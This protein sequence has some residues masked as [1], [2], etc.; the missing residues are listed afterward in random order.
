VFALRHP[1]SG[2]GMQSIQALRDLINS[3]DSRIS[4]CRPRGAYPA[5]HGIRHL[6]QPRDD[7]G[8]AAATSQ[9][10]LFVQPD[11]RTKVNRSGAI[12][13]THA[14]HT[15]VPPIVAAAYIDEHC[16]AD[17]TVLDP[18]C[19][20]GMTGVGAGLVGRRAVLSDI[21][22]AAVHIARNYCQPCDSAAFSAAVER[23]LEAVGA[24]IDDLYCTEL[25]GADATVEH[26]VWSDVRACPTCA[27]TTLLRDHRSEGLRTLTCATCGRDAATTHADRRTAR[28]PPS[29][30]SA[31][32]VRARPRR[33]TQR[34][35]SDRRTGPRPSPRHHAP[36]RAFISIALPT[37]TARR[38]CR[39]TVR[40]REA[41]AVPRSERSRDELR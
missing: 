12:Y 31:E 38:P 27:T 19:G 39:D 40:Q 11:D 25:E 41:H 24:E 32:R 33:S 14:Y 16:P 18:F 17:G 13:G 36:P 1:S 37:S 20:S 2:F 3:A 34:S 7:M 29:P 5:A 30:R 4:E 26:V 6:W 15:K 9:M 22:P 21:S 28:F 23:V 8:D 35:G 10:P